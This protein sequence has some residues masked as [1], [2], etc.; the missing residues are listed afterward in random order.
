MTDHRIAVPVDVKRLVLHEAGY[1][2]ANPVCRHI[3]T[4]DVHHLDYVSD[5]GS[6]TPYN[7]LPLCPNP[8]AAS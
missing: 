4:L 3:L 6:N 2:C 7:L 5:G 1:R 8:Y